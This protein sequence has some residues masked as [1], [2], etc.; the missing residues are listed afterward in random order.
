M[1]NQLGGKLRQQKE[2]NHSSRI[3]TCSEPGH[4]GDCAHTR[5]GTGKHGWKCMLTMSLRKTQPLL[6]LG[7]TAHA[8]LCSCFL[9]DAG[10]NTSKHSVLFGS[11]NF[12]SGWIPDLAD[13][14]TGIGHRSEAPEN[15]VSWLAFIELKWYFGPEAFSLL[16]LPPAQHEAVW[17]TK[18]HSRHQQCVLGC[19]IHTI[20]AWAFCIAKG[21]PS[22]TPNLPPS[23]GSSHPG[24]LGNVSQNSWGSIFP[25]FFSGCCSH[26][27]IL[28]FSC[29][30]S[31]DLAPASPR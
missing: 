5:K 3:D 22:A 12:H 20:S 9:S 11:V 4:C 7:E 18:G 29:C 15:I 25:L 8:L 14:K 13:H 16:C 23:S 6:L 17:L 1:V 31:H 10:S 19:R 21:L 26:A 2:K 30:Y 27:V 28:S 24:C